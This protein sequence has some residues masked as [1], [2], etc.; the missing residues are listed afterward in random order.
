MLKLV[1]FKIV[2]IRQSAYLTRSPLVKYKFSF[3]KGPK[4]GLSYNKNSLRTRRLGN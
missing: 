3:S 1:Y 4:E 2:A